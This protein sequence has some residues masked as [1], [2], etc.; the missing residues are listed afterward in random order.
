MQNILKAASAH[1][2]FNPIQ[3][4]ISPNELNLMHSVSATRWACCDCAERQ[5][6]RAQG[7]G[8][9]CVC[10]CVCVCVCNPRAQSPCTEHMWLPACS[11]SLAFTSR[12]VMCVYSA[13][14][15]VHT[16][17]LP[18]LQGL[19]IQPQKGYSP[20]CSLQISAGAL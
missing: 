2:L 1:Q 9:A 18:C 16:W 20:P 8:R 7:E 3:R 17:P 4:A 13:Q 19:Q 11:R 15:C 6:L 10:V 12:D 14:V 5:C